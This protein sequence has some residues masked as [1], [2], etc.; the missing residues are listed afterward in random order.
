MVQAKSHQEANPQSHDSVRQPL[1]AVIWEHE[2]LYA[3]VAYLLHTPFGRLYNG[4]VRLNAFHSLCLAMQAISGQLVSCTS[5]V[6]A[7]WKGVHVYD[8]SPC[9]WSVASWSHNSQKRHK[10]C[11][12]LAKTHRRERER[13]RQ[14]EIDSSKKLIKGSA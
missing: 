9:I 7:T 2:G 5:A 13:E 12:H 8:K 10:T 3:S 11:K 1:G 6:R 14:R 4:N